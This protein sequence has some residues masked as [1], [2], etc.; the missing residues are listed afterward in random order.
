MN[1]FVSFLLL[2]SSTFVYYVPKLD[3]RFMELENNLIVD[4]YM[5]VF[6]LFL[7]PNSSTFVY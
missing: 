1:V 6:V 2:N 7:L 5:N 3:S 4:E